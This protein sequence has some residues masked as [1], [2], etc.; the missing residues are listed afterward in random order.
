MAWISRKDHIG[1]LLELC[2]GLKKSDGANYWV[3]QG[4]ETE[5]R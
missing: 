3:P 4:R 5:S 2:F 1:I